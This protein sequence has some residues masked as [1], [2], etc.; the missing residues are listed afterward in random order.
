MVNWESAVSPA[1]DG[2]IDPSSGKWTALTSLHAARVA[3]LDW[4]P[5]REF[6][7]T[8]KRGRR[9]HSFIVLP[10]GFDS[11]RT[12]PLCVL[13]HGGAANMW[14]DNVT[15]RWNYHL[16]GAPGYVLLLTDYTGST[17]YGERPARGK[18]FAEAIVTF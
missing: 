4:Q 10:P 8:S 5:L 2:R 15:Y 7:F 3:S 11:T 9:L 18:Q 16:L 17:S 14:T 6:T 12:Y 13:I 1:E